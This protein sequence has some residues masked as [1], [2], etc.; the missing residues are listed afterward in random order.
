MFPQRLGYIEFAQAL[1]EEYVQGIGKGEFEAWEERSL[2]NHRKAV[3]A[4][5]RR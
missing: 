3:S 4:A 2:L 1:A 5:Q